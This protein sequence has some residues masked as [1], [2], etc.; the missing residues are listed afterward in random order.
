MSEEKS[1]S[2]MSEEL[3]RFVEEF[4]EKKKKRRAD[5]K[6]LIEKLSS[7][8]TK[9]LHSNFCDYL[10]TFEKN[11][12][13]LFKHDQR[14]FH[15]ETRDRLDNLGLQAAFDND[16]F[17]TKLYWTIYSWMGRGI[18]NLE[19]E[20]NFKNSIKENKSAIMELQ[21]YKLVLLAQ[22]DLVYVKEKLVNL[23][24]SLKIT[25][26]TAQTKIVPF[27]K[28]LH[29]L[30]PELVPPVDNKYILA[31]FYHEK[32]KKY[33]NSP[34]ILS[35]WRNQFRFPYDDK[36][37][38]DDIFPHLREIA[39]QNQDVI[40]SKIKQHKRD[41]EYLKRDF[42]TSETKVIDNAIIG[43]VLDENLVK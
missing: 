28:T 3:K 34:S 7:E 5:L 36:W 17:L 40:K 21:K 4:G 20:A 23:L 16:E 14:K 32:G 10:E 29:H 22:T 11:F 26:P 9:A 25:I 33:H 27:T 31:F 37:I 39:T 6:P 38:M 1:G 15:F 19:R 12:E 8:R 18:T 41:E 13:K 24:D 2:K 43:F 35:N 30:L 42:H